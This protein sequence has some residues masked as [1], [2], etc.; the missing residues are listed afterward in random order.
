VICN[1]NLSKQ[2]LL[3]TPTVK[4]V[5]EQQPMIVLH[6]IMRAISRSTPVIASHSM[7]TM[8]ILKTIA[9]VTFRE[10]LGCHYSCLT[11]SN[12][13]N[14]GCLTCDTSL[15]YSSNYECICKVNNVSVRMDIMTLQIIRHVL[16]VIIHV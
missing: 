11:C 7:H 16:S 14:S 8:T 15:W 5:M 4:R 3:A 12:D 6:A 10:T 1:Y 2:V 9:N 13:T